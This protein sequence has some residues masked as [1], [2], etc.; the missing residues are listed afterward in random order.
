MPLAVAL[1]HHPVTDR[2]GD[3]ITSAVTNL[4]LHDLARTAMTY[5]VDG[6]YVVTPVEEQQ[7]LVQRLL[8]HWRQGHGAHYNP[9][10]ARALQL[11]EVVDTLDAALG[12]WRQRSSD[13]AVPL[14]TGA[15]REDGIGFPAATSLLR[16]KPLLLTLGT[17]SGLADEIF[18]HGWP[19]LE[20]IAGVGDYNHLPVRAAAA[21][22]LDRIRT[23]EAASGAARD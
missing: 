22:M 8:D 17:G 11:V 20:P 9:D 6:Y 4:D 16:E 19:V 5:G 3:V 7:R 23:C 18:G 13:S 21:I 1:V 12:K 2:N 15:G 10:R 14:L